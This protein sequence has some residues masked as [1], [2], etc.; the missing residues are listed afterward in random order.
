MRVVRADR[1]LLI[2][3]QAR[4]AMSAATL[5][6]EL[7]VTGSSPPR[8]LSPGKRAPAY[9]HPLDT[10]LISLVGLLVILDPIGTAAVLVGITPRDSQARRRARALR[11]TGSGRSRAQAADDDDGGGRRAWA[12]GT[13]VPGSSTSEDQR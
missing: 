2:L 6:T 5:V 4:G 7:E 12:R 9:G 8:V 1:L 10:F 3:L 11:G 13:I